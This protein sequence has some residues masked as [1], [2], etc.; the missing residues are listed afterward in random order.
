MATPRQIAANGAN[1][2]KS[3]G[4]L[5]TEGKVKASLNAV[6]HGL[7]SGLHFLPDE[8]PKEFHALLAD[9]KSDY[10]PATHTEQ[11][12][13]EKMALNQW[14]SLRATRL[15]GLSLSFREPWQPIPTEL[16]LLIRYQ[17]AADR[18]FHKAHTELLKLQKE[19]KKLEIGFVSETA[20]EAPAGSPADPEIPSPEDASPD[21]APPAT[22]PE[23]QKSTPPDEQLPKAA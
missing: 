15:Q 16:G 5:T 13:V 2:K 8:D 4:P 19:R 9:L 3:T 1:A 21:L 17:T 11:I 23:E 20:E 18:A 22:A 10:E 6:S 14:L 7:T 12:L